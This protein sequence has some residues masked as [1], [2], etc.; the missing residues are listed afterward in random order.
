MGKCFKLSFK[1]TFAGIVMF[2][3]L[4]K[5]LQVCVNV[6]RNHVLLS[7]CAV[8]LAACAELTSVLTAVWLLRS[9]LVPQPRY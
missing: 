7:S 6:V 1:L 5:Y 3:Y 9:P 8:S 2:Y 4:H